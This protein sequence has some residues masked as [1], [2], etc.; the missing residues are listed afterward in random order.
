MAEKWCI[1]YGVL[2]YDKAQEINDRM[3]NNKSGEKG[4]KNNSSIKKK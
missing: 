1:E 3:H 4:G 2:P